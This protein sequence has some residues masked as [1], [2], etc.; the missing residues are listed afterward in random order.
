M[1]KVLT[2][3]IFSKQIFNLIKFRINNFEIQVTIRAN[4][5]T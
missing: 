2:D 4:I 5:S 3:A 1:Q